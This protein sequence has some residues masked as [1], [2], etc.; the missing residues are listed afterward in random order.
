MTTKPAREDRP[1]LLRPRDPAGLIPPPHV[2]ALIFDWDGTVADTHEAGYRAFRRTASAL[3]LNVD[4][5]WYWDRVGLSSPDTF[6]ELLQ[7]Q[8]GADVGA[9]EIDDLVDQR[10][11]F[12]LDELGRVRVFPWMQEL[13]E[14]EA[15][16]R[17][18]AVV[19]VGP[20]AT[21]E[22]TLLSLGL[23]RYFDVLVTRD[24]VAERKPAPDGYV[25]AVRRLARRPQDCLVYED[26]DE[27][28]VAAHS[29]GIDVVDVR[30]L[31]GSH[32]RV[33]P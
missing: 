10:D 14:R 20:R 24:D 31:T 13:I 23:N 7:E 2:G 8:S 12:Y 1:A 19:T 25:E 15:K 9:P 27:G 5:E 3:G 29:A 30:S 6:G 16:R 21:L 28:I 33:D 11:R 4:R 26:S 17:A 22:P 32:D 18:L